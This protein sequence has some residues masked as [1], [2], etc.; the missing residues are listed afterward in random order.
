MRI[1]PDRLLAIL[2]GTICASVR[3]D[4]HDL[5]ARQ[6]AILLA[7]T[8]ESGL[9]TVRGLAAALNIS[10]PAISRSLDR[11]CELGLAARDPDPRDR[12]SVLVVPTDVGRDYVTALRDLLQEAARPVPVRRSPRRSQPAAITGM[13]AA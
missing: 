12:R 4:A 10:K 1:D 2:H 7:I 5:S 8:L 9:H 6:M 3:S 13:V 11:L